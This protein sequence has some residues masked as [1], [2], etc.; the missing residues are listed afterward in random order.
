MIPMI[1][2]SGGLMVKAAASVLCGVLGLGFVPRARHISQHGGWG[3]SQK[4]D[5]QTNEVKNGTMPVTQKA[6]CGFIGLGIVPKVIN[7]ISVHI[8]N[9]CPMDLYLK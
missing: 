2:F 9:N 5:I 3:L 1:V 7:S 6:R 4:T 8:I